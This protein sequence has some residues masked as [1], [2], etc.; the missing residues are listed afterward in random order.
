M[1][2]LVSFLFQNLSWRMIRCKTGCSCWWFVVQK[3]NWNRIIFVQSS[4]IFNM[5]N[6]CM[7][8]FRCTYSNTHVEPN[9]HTERKKK[10]IRKWNTVK[11]KFDYDFV[12][13]YAPFLHP[14]PAPPHIHVYCRK[15]KRKII[16]IR[17]AHIYYRI[18]NWNKLQVSFVLFCLDIRKQSENLF[19]FR[20]YAKVF[21]ECLKF[22]SV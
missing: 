7:F 18:L 12:T 19:N 10:K 2:Y 3:F 14:R 20:R 17:C 22:S 16:W 8:T 15:S 21:G 4:K 11:F 9:T 1:H 6:C 13:S 5:I